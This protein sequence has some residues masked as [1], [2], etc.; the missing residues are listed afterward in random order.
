MSG[1][2]GR[3]YSITGN[4]SLAASATLPALTVIGTTAVRTMVYDYILGSSGS[5]ADAAARLTWQRCTTAG[6]A[7]SSITPQAIDPGNPAAVTTSGLATFSVG[8]TLTAS[9]L[10]AEVGINQRATFRWIAAPGGELMIPATSANGLA[11]MPIAVSAAFTLEATV[12]I[13]E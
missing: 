4:T 1:Y 9:A 5:P 8:P 3:N 10:L 12:Y 2:Q 11:L 7:G 13:A 6:T